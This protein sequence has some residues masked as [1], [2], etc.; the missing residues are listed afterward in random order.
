MLNDILF[1]KS[2]IFNTFKPDVYKYTDNRKGVKIHYFAYMVSGSCK[3]ITESE[4]LNINEGDVFY[5]AK[6]CKYQSFW[7]GNPKVEFISLG[8]TFMPNF[9]SKVFPTQIIESTKAEVEL[10]VKISAKGKTDAEDIGTFYTLV[11]LL[12]PKMAYRQEEKKSQLVESAKKYVSQNPDASVREIAK[13]VAVSESS[14]YA[15]FKNHSEMSINEYRQN[16]KMEKAKEL[17]I[18]TNMPIEEISEKLRFSSGSY[19]RKCFKT[20]FGTTPSKIRK[21]YMI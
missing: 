7:Y 5:I 13:A 8:F 11:G 16:V 21:Q 15:A 12:L 17:L 1:S 19:F 20:H 14:L 3:I 2:F 4:T 18:S 9:E 10:F 6:G